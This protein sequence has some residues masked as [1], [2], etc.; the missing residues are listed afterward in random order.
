AL[1]LGAIR[2]LV[3]RGLVLLHRTR[4]RYLRISCRNGP[5][6]DG[7]RGPFGPTTAVNSTLEEFTD[8]SVMCRDAWANGCVAWPALSARRSPPCGSI[9][10]HAVLTGAAPRSRPSLRAPD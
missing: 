7:P 4:P 6:E 3:G 9:F 1:S 10:G 5:Y 2:R 8:F